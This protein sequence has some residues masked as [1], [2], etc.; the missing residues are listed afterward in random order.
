MHLQSQAAQGDQQHPLLLLLGRP[1]QHQF[2]RCLCARTGRAAPQVFVRLSRLATIRLES[3]HVAGRDCFLRTAHAV[4]G[5]FRVLVVE[6][7]TGERGAA[8]AAGIA[9]A[10]GVQFGKVEVV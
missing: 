7:E 5:G 2:H 9:A 1:L 3:G 4:F 10:G 8:D 6:G